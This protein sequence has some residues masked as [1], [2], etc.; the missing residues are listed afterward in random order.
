MTS[1]RATTRRMTLKAVL[2][3]CASFDLPALPRD[4]GRS[5]DLRTLAPLLGRSLRHH[6]VLTTAASARE[7]PQRLQN[8]RVT[9]LPSPH[10]PQT[11][12]PGCS[13]RDGGSRRTCGGFLC[14][15]WGVTA[16][17]W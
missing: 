15:S 16:P 1:T 5:P 2:T 7:V 4:F 8:L 13:F 9:L 17:G 6:G 12:S 10:S 11:R 14:A 3:V